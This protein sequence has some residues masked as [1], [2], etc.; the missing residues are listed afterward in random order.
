MKSTLK[1]FGVILLISAILPVLF[2]VGLILWGDWHDE[3]SG[4][5]Y[6]DYI[7]DGVCNIAVIPVIGDITTFSVAVDE[8]EELLSTSMSD[9]LAMLG[10]AERDPGISGVMLL[11]DSFGGSPSAGMMIAEELK[12]SSMPSAALVFDI[13]ASSAYLAASG[14]D[15]IISTPMADIGSIG[16]TMSY[17][18]NTQYNEMN[19]QE[20]IELTSAKYKDAGS[21]DR[22]LTPEE[23]A[24]FQRDLD[25]AHSEF[26]RMISEN[27]DIPEDEVAKLADGS[28]LFASLAK[29]KKL[30]D[31]IG[32]KETVRAWFAE[33]LELP[34]EDIV[35]C[36]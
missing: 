35:F 24:L 34:V 10:K 13:A 32:N 17:L 4:Y 25:L 36:P 27:R 6:S 19:G 16:V 5:N 15:T 23:K 21:P 11:V 31:D 26:I 20:Y 18:Q 12:N 33:K 9:T 22:L 1:V 8:G 7:S 2:Y 14:A 30:V 3:W 29:E 28:T